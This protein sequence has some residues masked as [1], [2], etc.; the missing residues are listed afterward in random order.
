M[1]DYRDPVNGQLRP[2]CVGC[3]WVYYPCNPLAAIAVVE[4]DEG[5]V[6]T[7]PAGGMPQA[8][9]SLPG[10][11][12][13]YGETPESCLARAVWEQTGFEV[14]TVAELVRFLQLGTSFGPA[15]MFGFRVRVVGGRLRTDGP[16]GPAAVYPLNEM[17]A[18][19][20]VRQANRR[21][22]DAYLAT[23]I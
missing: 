2:T 11:Y 22:M 7:H 17:P 20:P 1:R 12:I 14:E 3:G 15:L 19:I 10:D 13:E 8:P 16:E 4:T 5:I 18:L 9:A 23:R 6:M 21:V